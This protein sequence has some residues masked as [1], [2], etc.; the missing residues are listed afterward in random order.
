MFPM[1]VI[2]LKGYLL[3]EFE[4]LACRTATIPHTDWSFI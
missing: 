4:V 3:D 1:S 2:Y